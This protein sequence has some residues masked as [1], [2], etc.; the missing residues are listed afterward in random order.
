MEIIHRNNKCKRDKISKA[1]AMVIKNYLI[2][3]LLFIGLV[4]Y[5]QTGIGT[6]TPHE[7]SQ[8]E[9]F[10]TSKGVLLPKITL[11]GEADKA[12]ITGGDPAVGLIVY[13]TGLDADFPIKGF[14]FWNGIK[15]RLFLDANT[16]KA[17]IVGTLIKNSGVL[18]PNSYTA[19][20]DYNGVLE[21]LYNGG[22]GGYYSEDEAYLSNG[23]SFKIQPGQATAT[24]KLTY[25]VKGKPTV[26]SPNSIANVPI[27]FFNNNL[28]NINI[29]GATVLLTNQY[30]LYRSTDVS[31]GTTSDQAGVNM[32]Y[33]GTRLIW[34]KDD[35]AKIESIVLPETGAYIFSFRLYGSTNGNAAAAAPFYLSALK[36]IG[37]LP[38]VD[39]SPDL[40]LDILELTLVKV[41]NYIYY[42]YSANLTVS[43]KAGDRIYFKIS[44]ADDQ[45]FKWKL[46]NGSDT[47]NY[48]RMANRT[49][50]FF[51][52]L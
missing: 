13:N 10:S 37:N 29:G 41:P 40:V 23:L 27:K 31:V 48:E 21:V 14:M 6:V 32:G 50:M 3:I 39:L 17:Q 7:S 12:S 16:T 46:L 47:L 5:S 42:T 11:K 22:N 19:G 4:S 20:T 33:K 18:T 1:K 45:P 35:D 24:G 43:G 15:W 30:S 49:S 9:I 51:W 52:K 2:I 26:S 44:G 34:R 28:G 25:V 38:A 36:Q 8:L